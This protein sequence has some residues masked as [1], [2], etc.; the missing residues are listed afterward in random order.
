[1]FMLV[2]DSLTGQHNFSP[3]EKVNTFVAAE[4][5]SLSLTLKSC[6]KIQ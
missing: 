6:S 4:S 5:Q 1:M 2:E 3:Q